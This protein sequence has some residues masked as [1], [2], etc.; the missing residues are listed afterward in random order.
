[1]LQL[2]IGLKLLLNEEPQN[3]V[4]V[5]WKA[6]FEESEKSIKYWKQKFEEEDKEGEELAKRYNELNAKFDALADSHSRLEFYDQ[7]TKE[8]SNLIETLRSELKEKESKEKVYFYRDID[9]GE[10]NK[11][12]KGE[13]VALDID[14]NKVIA[15]AREGSEV[16]EAVK[17]GVKKSVLVNENS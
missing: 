1:M 8:Q 9:L 6:K 3:K 11:I 17:I 15:N 12:S 5:D 14:I 4:E 7:V 16:F 13:M 2:P 10:W